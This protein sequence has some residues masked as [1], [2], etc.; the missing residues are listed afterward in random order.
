MIGA[1]LEDGWLLEEGGLLEEGVKICYLKFSI[2][3][4]VMYARSAFMIS[5]LAFQGVGHCLQRSW[6]QSW[7]YFWKIHHQIIVWLLSERN[8]IQ[9]SQQNIWWWFWICLKLEVL[10]IAVEVDKYLNQMMHHK[11]EAHDLCLTVS[12]LIVLKAIVSWRNLE[13]RSVKF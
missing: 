1:L 4:L 10:R 7:S 12:F 13:E 8:D 5:M 3:L 11:I 2:C 6:S 9:Y